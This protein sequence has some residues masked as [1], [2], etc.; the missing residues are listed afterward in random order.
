MKVLLCTMWLLSHLRHPRLRSAESLTCIIQTKLD[1]FFE[2][3][4]QQTNVWI[5]KKHPSRSR[6]ILDDFRE[7]YFWLNQNTHDLSRVMSWWDY[8]YQIAGMAN[9]FVILLI[10]R[11]FGW[12]PINNL[13]HE[14]SAVVGGW[15]TLFTDFTLRYRKQLLRYAQ[16]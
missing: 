8:G 4:R 13:S 3:I 11:L 7:A 10:I 16:R 1:T 2:L 12:L 5:L 15:P 6:H 14:T 9:R